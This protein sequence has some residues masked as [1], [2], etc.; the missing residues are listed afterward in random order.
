MG[1]GHKTRFSRPKSSENVRKPSHCCEF[2]NN[3]MGFGHEAGPAA[4]P[5][6]QT[7]HRTPIARFVGSRTANR[8]RNCNVPGRSLLG[9]S[10]ENDPTN[11]ELPLRGISNTRI[12]HPIHRFAASAPCPHRVRNLSHCCAFPNNVMGYGHKTRFSRPKSSENVRK[13]SH[14]CGNENDVMGYGPISTRPA[15]R[16]PN[17]ASHWHCRD[18]R[19]A[20][21]MQSGTEPSSLPPK[22]TPPKNNVM[23]CGPRALRYGPGARFDGAT[24]GGRRG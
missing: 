23:G 13:P 10:L 18:Q 16:K 3:V 19:E 6:P 5:L 15:S 4:T 2:S 12:G 17:G 14:C 22:N 8:R 20:P 1:Y 7:G 11:R 9:H 21:L 24:R